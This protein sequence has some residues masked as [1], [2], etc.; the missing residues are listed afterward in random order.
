MAGTLAFVYRG[1]AYH[2][3][4]TQLNDTFNE[5]YGIDT[6]KTAAI[7]DMHKEVG[8]MSPVNLEP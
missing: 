8:N 3:L 6:A 1:Q 5:Y 2:D 7:D 4:Q